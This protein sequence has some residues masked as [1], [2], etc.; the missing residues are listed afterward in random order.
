VTH[1]WLAPTLASLVFV[2]ISAP[3]VSAA[4]YAAVLQWSGRVDLTFPVSGVIDAV[5]ARPGQRVGKGELLANLEPTLFK[6]G[7][8]ESRADLDRLGEDHAD[9][10]RELE[11]VRE[12][13]ARTVA[14]TTELDAA[15]LRLARVQSA[16]AAAQARVER[17]R[18]L[19]SESEL[20]APFDALILARPGEPGMVISGQCQPAMVY[21]VARG[22]ELIALAQ[23]DAGQAG[24]VRL[25]GELEVLVGG[26]PVK[27]RVAG[28][29]AL[30]HGRYGLEVAIP[31]Q[32]GVLAGQP[33][34]VRLP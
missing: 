31:R 18:R 12:L 13:Y 21:S 29:T 30:P 5:T 22:D 16:L 3:P 23:L 9:A 10:K 25:D 34:T 19:L 14:T 24:S 1:K 17:A 33:A 28:L 6:A 32:P 27:G 8:A 20:R 15:K 4:E 2:Y 7:V 26:K 11:R